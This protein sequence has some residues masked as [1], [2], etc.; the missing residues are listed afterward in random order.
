[1]KFPNMIE[2]NHC[3]ALEKERNNK[4]IKNAG[5]RLVEPFWW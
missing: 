5:I 2:D 4:V 1:M 3:K